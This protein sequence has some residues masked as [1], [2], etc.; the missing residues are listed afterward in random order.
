[1]ICMEQWGSTDITSCAP[2]SVTCH[3][4]VPVDFPNTC[5]MKIVRLFYRIIAR[6]GRDIYTL[7][8]SFPNQQ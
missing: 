7:T 2:W 4:V 6:Y 8:Q 1:M 3:W 5:P